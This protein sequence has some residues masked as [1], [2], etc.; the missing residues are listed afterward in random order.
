MKST[1]SNDTAG[2]FAYDGLDRVI[3]EKA[4]LGLLTSLATHR[5]GLTFG[6]LKALCALTD[7]NLN[8][9]LQALQ[10][11]GFVTVQKDGA[12]RNQT[13]TCRITPLGRKRFAEYLQVLESV[14]KD[15]V[16]AAEP[17]TLK[18]KPAWNPT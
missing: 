1:K 8:R 6:E 14:V 2:R 18:T 17:S 11:S 15:A 16:E 3:H 12:G 9:H 7:G 5:K 13:T 10:E 4:R